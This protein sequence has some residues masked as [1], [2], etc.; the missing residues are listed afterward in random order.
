MT[1]TRRRP[2]LEVQLG[3]LANLDTAERLPF[4]DDVPDAALCR[5]W[6]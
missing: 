5:V 1:A 2:L 4:L 3:R 6:R